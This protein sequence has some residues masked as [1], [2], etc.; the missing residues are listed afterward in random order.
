MWGFFVYLGLISVA[1]F[2]FFFF[3]AVTSKSFL[4]LHTWT[5]IWSHIDKVR[6]NTMG[7]W[8]GWGM[9][10]NESVLQRSY[11]VKDWGSYN[12]NL[13]AYLCKSEIYSGL[14]RILMY[15]MR[16]KI[17]PAVSG[18]TNICTYFLTCLWFDQ[19]Y[20]IWQSLCGMCS[21][22]LCAGEYDQPYASTENISTPV[23]YEYR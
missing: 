19:F 13:K 14:F 1:F 2:F 7:S 15:G 12:L 3:P 9:H 5:Q 8:L 11:E 16:N 18:S 17:F 23:E 10:I 20:R 4:V 6:F 21:N 22:A